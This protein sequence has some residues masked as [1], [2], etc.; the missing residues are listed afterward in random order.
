MYLIMGPVTEQL[1]A[2]LTA[3]EERRTALLSEL[4]EQD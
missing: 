1:R 4:A 3:L 2:K